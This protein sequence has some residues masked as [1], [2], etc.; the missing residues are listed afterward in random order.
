L[1]SGVIT[2]RFIKRSPL[3]DNDL[4]IENYQS[5]VAMSICVIRVKSTS[6]PS[7]PS[8]PPSLSLSLSLSRIVIET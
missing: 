3:N 1:R 4:L 6:V 5:L 2:V 7:F 8:P